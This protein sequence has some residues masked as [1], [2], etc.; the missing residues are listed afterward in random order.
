[1]ENGAGKGKRGGGTGMKTKTRNRG[2]YFDGSTRGA[3]KKRHHCWR[4][5]AGTEGERRR[6]RGREGGYDKA[7]LSEWARDMLALWTGGEEAENVTMDKIRLSAANEAKNLIGDLKA[8]VERTRA[9]A[10]KANCAGKWP[11]VT[12]GYGPLTKLCEWE[13]K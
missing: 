6:K 10:D 1:M 3:G 8:Y 4:A 5:D 2:V 12:R 7:A 11:G 13:R 9:K